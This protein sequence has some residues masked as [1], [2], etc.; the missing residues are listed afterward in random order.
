MLRFN[1]RINPDTTV[2]ET[3]AQPVQERAKIQVNL[4][5]PLQVLLHA[6]HKIIV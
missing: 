5:V 6:S 2:V 4:C 1:I 3:G